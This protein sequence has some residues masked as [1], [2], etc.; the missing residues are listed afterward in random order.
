MGRGRGIIVET[1]V[2]GSKYKVNKGRLDGISTI[3][4]IQYLFVNSFLSSDPFHTDFKGNGELFPT[5]ISNV[6]PRI[7]RV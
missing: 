6:C 7:S 5:P 1:F 4:I 3:L 2:P